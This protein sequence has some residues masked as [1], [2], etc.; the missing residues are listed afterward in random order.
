MWNVLEVSIGNPTFGMEYSFGVIHQE[1]A[2]LRVTTNAG[3]TERDLLHH[4]SALNFKLKFRG[5]FSH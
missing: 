2:K 5:P 4:D 1:E 3:P